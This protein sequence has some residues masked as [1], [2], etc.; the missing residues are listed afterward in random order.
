[1]KTYWKC[2]VFVHFHSVGKEKW[3]QC[4]LLDDLKLHIKAWNKPWN[5]SKNCF[6]TAKWEQRVRMRRGS[7]VPAC[8]WQNTL[9]LGSWLFLTKRRV[10]LMLNG[11]FVNAFLYQSHSV[12]PLPFWGSCWGYGS[13][14]H[15]G[16]KV[17]LK[18]LMWTEPQIA[19]M[20]E[21]WSSKAHNSAKGECRDSGS[22][23]MEHYLLSSP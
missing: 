22:C 14:K 15:D 19:Q 7:A 10:Q 20:E 16:G 12:A 9:E 21:L 6:I 4:H 1:M 2:Q 8:K 13:E 11:L 18:F 23:V 3:W 17:V 5:H